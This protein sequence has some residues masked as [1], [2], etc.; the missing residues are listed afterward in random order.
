LGGALCAE[1]EVAS[2]AWFCFHCFEADIIDPVFDQVNINL[3]VVMSASE[4]HQGNALN[5]YF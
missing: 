1:P 5:S 4:R 2:E 3:S